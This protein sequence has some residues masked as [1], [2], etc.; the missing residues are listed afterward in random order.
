MLKLKSSRSSG[1]IH[2]QQ[3]QAEKD[4]LPTTQ[5][6]ATVFWDKKGVPPVEFMQ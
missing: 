6:M 3:K 5:L 1:F 4:C 2:I